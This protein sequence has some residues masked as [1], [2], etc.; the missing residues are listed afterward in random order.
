MVSMTMSVD[1]RPL[2]ERLAA[3]KK[4]REVNDD[5]SRIAQ[6]IKEKSEIQRSDVGGAY[7]AANMLCE[8]SK[9]FIFYLSGSDPDSVLN[10]YQNLFRDIWFAL[11]GLDLVPH[12]GSQQ[13]SES[14]AEIGE[15]MAVFRLHKI[16]SD[17]SISG[18]DQ[19]V[20]ATRQALE[21]LWYQMGDPDADPLLAD[22]VANEDH[23]VEEAKSREEAPPERIH[24]ISLSYQ[25]WLAGICDVPGEVSKFVTKANI[26][27]DLEDGQSL[28]YIERK[29]LMIRYI[30]IART[31][32]DFLGSFETCYP[33][34]IN[35]SQR[36][37][38]FN[39]FRGTL[40]RVAGVTNAR[41]RELED[42]SNRDAHQE[43]FLAKLDAAMKINA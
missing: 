18:K 5:L 8:G 23:A 27:A 1:F 10:D 39:T 19:L 35:N 16:L 32:Y 37:G 13:D 34:V 6:T 38:W 36:R 9:D 40:G 24:Q 7:R 20:S 21:D 33:A 31:T 4:R 12:F 2:E 43:A 29:K 41:V 17:E 30:H 28:N 11:K 22:L 3:L 42:L 25:S 14:G 15:A 26:A